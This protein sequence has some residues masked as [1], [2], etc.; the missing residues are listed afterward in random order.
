MAETTIK[1]ARALA[2]IERYDR[3]MWSDMAS[4]LDLIPDDRKQEARKILIEGERA[5]SETIDCAMDIANTGF[6]QLAGAAVLR[7]QG[8]LK[9]TT[10]RPEVQS[11]VL[12]MAFDGDAY[13]ANILMRRFYPSERTR[14]QLN[15]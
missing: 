8:W 13:L 10:F 2:I 1:A 15:P 11:N 5:A 12:D 7:R 6:C 3:Q 14:I 4:L 9:A